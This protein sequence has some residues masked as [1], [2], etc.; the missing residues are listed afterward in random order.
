MGRKLDYVIG[1]TGII[2]SVTAWVLC[3]IMIANFLALEETM[4]L[5]LKLMLLSVVVK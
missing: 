4:N 2:L 1:G 3:G 5:N